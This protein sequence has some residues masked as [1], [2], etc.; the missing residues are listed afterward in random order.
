MG[1]MNGILRAALTA[2]VLTILAVSAIF[3]PP[4]TPAAPAASAAID[5]LPLLQDYLRIDTSN[6]PGNEMKTVNYENKAVTA[7]F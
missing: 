2:T 3:A 6:P 4:A 5:P 1:V 7:R